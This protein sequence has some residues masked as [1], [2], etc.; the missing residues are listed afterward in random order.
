MS[1]V[2]GPTAAARRNSMA[3]KRT[4][5]TLKR[6]PSSENGSAANGTNAKPSSPPNL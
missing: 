2:V 5:S 3:Q 1:G 4:S 6:G